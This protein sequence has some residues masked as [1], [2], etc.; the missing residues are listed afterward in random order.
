DVVSRLH[1]RRRVE[2]REIW[3]RVRP[4]EGRERP[5]ARAEPGVED[6]GFLGE[7]VCR[8]TAG[9]TLAWAGRICRDGHVAVLAVPGRDAVTPPQL[10]RHVPVVDVRQPVLPLLF[11]TGRQDASASRSGRLEGGG[12]EGLGADEPLRLEARLDGI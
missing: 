3:R 11:E 6:V 4:A 5:Q 8:T 10:A 9:L 1:D 2:A 7:L 12:G